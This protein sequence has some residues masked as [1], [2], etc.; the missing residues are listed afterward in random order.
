MER[1]SSRLGP[2]WPHQTASQ[3]HEGLQWTTEGEWTRGRQAGRLQQFRWRPAC[4]RM[5]TAATQESR[6]AWV[7][8]KHEERLKSWGLCERW[9]AGLGRHQCVWRPFSGRGR[10][11]W[12]AGAHAERARLKVTCKDGVEQR[13]EETQGFWLFSIMIW[14]AKIAID[15]YHMLLFTVNVLCSFC[16]TVLIFLLM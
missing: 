14:T 2:E 3:K 9:L 6:H 13:E 15:M 10:P 16:K 11:P 12:R 8:P 7:G 5:E 1:Q 4:R